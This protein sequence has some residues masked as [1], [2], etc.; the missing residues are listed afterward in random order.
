[1]TVCTFFFLRKEVWL[2]LYHREGNGANIHIGLWSKGPETL[3][4]K[5]E[6]IRRVCSNIGSGEGVFLRHSQKGAFIQGISQ[7]V[8]SEASPCLS[9]PLVESH[10][11][12]IC[13]VNSHVY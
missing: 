2:R 4:E 1:M 6:V 3:S 5:M 10:S 7:V 9:T 11:S 12:L 8:D 13:I